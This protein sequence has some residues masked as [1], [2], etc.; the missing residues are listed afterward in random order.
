[1]DNHLGKILANPVTAAPNIDALGGPMACPLAKSSA[2]YYVNM[3]GVVQNVTVSPEAKKNM[4]LFGIEKHYYS[5]DARCSSPWLE[6]S[7]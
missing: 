4:A 5:L 3:Q 6:L 1:M 2:K 7:V